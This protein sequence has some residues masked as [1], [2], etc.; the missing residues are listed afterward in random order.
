VAEEKE[1]LLVQ[2]IEDRVALKAEEEVHHGVVDPQQILE[3]GLV[4]VAD[5]RRKKQA[6]LRRKAA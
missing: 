6:A 4:A 2:Q 3:K 5:A 1:V